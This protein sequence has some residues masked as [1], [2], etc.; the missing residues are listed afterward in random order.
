MMDIER[1]D[2]TNGGTRMPCHGC[3][4][5]EKSE[6]GD[7]VKFDDYEKL[8]AQR[9]ELESQLRKSRKETSQYMRRVAELGGSISINTNNDIDNIKAQRDELLMA[10]KEA[11]QELSYCLTY[12]HK[13]NDIKM[14][15]KNLI[16]KYEAS[17]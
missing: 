13:D 11:D 4:T 15:I 10:L 1:F 3:Y 17:S 2:C 7:Y 5:M 12:H 9:D 14:R 6:L 16:A 8:K